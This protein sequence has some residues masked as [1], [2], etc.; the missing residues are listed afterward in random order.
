M[1]RTACGGADV[2]SHPVARG[3]LD[4]RLGASLDLTHRGDLPHRRSPTGWTVTTLH[5]GD[6][7]QSPPGVGP[8]SSAVGVGVRS[9]SRWRKRTGRG[10]AKPAGNVAAPHSEP[11]GRGRP[12][13][14]SPY[15]NLHPRIRFSDTKGDVA[16]S[17]T[18]ARVTLGWI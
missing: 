16:P 13:Q 11:G 5:L 1:F 2:L 17:E 14:T 8:G 7:C 15:R 4:A 6:Q 10:A 3:G 12:V 18:Q 9:G